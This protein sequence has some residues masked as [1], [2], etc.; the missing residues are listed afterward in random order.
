MKLDKILKNSFL[1]IV[2]CFML[3][4]CATKKV[5]KQI[6]LKKRKLTECF[7]TCCFSWTTNITIIGLLLQAFDDSISFAYSFSVTPPSILAGIIPVSLWGVGTRD[8][9]LAY[10]L[11]G[12]VSAEN[13]ISAG[14]LYTTLVYWFLGLLGTPLLLISQKSTRRLTN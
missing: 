12:S 11:E 1:V 8:G 2:A 9:A 3:T 4:A 5:S 7:L 14:I 6:C 13:V 10:F